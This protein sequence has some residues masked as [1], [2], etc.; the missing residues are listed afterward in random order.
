MSTIRNGVIGTV[1]AGGGIWWAVGAVRATAAE[2]DLSRIG[3]GKPTIVQVHD[4]QCPM[5]T[6]LQREVRKALKC[7][8]ECDVVYLVANIRGDEGRQFA[9]QHRVPHVTLMLFDEA[10]AVQDVLRGVRTEEE[11]KPV[12]QAHAG[13]SIG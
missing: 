9:S 13:V 5:C 6:Q 10:S 1:A 8:G 7:F 3:Q 11:L 12:F 2:Q 4:P